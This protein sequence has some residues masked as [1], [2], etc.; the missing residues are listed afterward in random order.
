MIR[1]PQTLVPAL[2]LSLIV[3]AHAAGLNDTGQ[4][5]CYNDTAADSVAASDPASIARDAGTHPRQDCRY[6]RDAVAALG[7]LPKTGAGTKGFDFTKIANNGST[8]AAAAALGA[9]PTDWACTKDNTTGLTWEVKTAGATDLRYYLRTYTWYSTDA[10]TNGGNAGVPNGGINTENFAADV[11]AAALCTYTDWRLPTPRELRSLAIVG[12]SGPDPAYF[13]NLPL[14]HGYWTST[15]FSARQ[16]SAWIVASTHFYPNYNAGNGSDKGN[17][18]YVLLV[19]G[20][21]F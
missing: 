6:G 1:F 17:S 20:G 18:L 14:N 4:D 19:R 16:T 13:P 15:T 10:A 12:G 21:H 2:L 7:L 9:A 11:N 5:T 8:L 3:P